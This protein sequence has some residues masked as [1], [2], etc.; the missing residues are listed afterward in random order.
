MSKSMYIIYAERGEYDDY[1]ILTVAWTPSK[2]KA[3]AWCANANAKDKKS[4]C[5]YIYSVAPLK[6]LRK[7][8]DIL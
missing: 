5:E 2:Q 6:K 1:E 7:G 4:R 8:T 3:E